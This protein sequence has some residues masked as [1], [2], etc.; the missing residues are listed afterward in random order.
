VLNATFKWEKKKENKPTQKYFS[1]N[2]PRSDE[3]SE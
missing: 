2:K 1:F 3:P